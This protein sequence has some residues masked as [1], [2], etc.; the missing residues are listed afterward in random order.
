M[1][2]LCAICGL[3][4]ATTKDHIPPRNLYPKPIENDI[5]LNTVP[6]CTKCNNGSSS[7]DEIFKVLIGIDTGEH[8]KDSQRI[9]DS[10]AATIAKNARVAGQIFSTKQRVLAGLRGPILEPAVAV[11]FDFKPYERVINRMVRGLHWME[12]GRAMASDAIVRVLPGAQLTQSLAADWLSLMHLLPLKKLNKDTFS[13]RYQIGEDGTHVWGMQFFSR[14]TTF[15]YVQ[16][17][18]A[19]RVEA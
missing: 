15:V 3:H 12:S 7:D 18:P 2:I 8:Q 17:P 13:Y 14:H 9:I 6:A 19:Q 1:P 16:E 4:P 11:Q 5:N 10:L